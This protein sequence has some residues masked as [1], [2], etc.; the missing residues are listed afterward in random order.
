MEITCS[1]KHWQLAILDVFLVMVLSSSYVPFYYILVMILI[2]FILTYLICTGLYIH[3]F[4]L[5]VF[6]SQMV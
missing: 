1:G 4:M 6:H 3:V 2:E 5:Y